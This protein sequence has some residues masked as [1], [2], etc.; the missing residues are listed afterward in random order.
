MFQTFEMIKLLQSAL[1]PSGLATLLVLA[2]LAI[3]TCK[4][5]RRFAGLLMSAATAVL[6]IFSNGLIPKLLLIPLE[7]AYPALKDPHQYPDARS[8]IVLTAYAVDD[9]NLPLSARM[10][11]SSA[12]RILEAANLRSS[13]PDCRV[14]VSGSATAARTMGR[15]LQLLGVPDALLSLDI[16]SNNTAASAEH[17]KFLIGNQPVFLVTSAGHM[18]RAI[19]VFRKNGM[20]PIPVPTDYQLLGNAWDATWKISAMHLQASDFA[21]HEYIGLAWYH[22]TNRL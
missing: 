17:M 21:V 20:T 10:N 11:A 9:E 8:I 14:I 5:T 1:L 22:L 18:R 19:G 16:M 3:V 15:Q 13:R 7:S 2:A 12:S 6:L 4:R